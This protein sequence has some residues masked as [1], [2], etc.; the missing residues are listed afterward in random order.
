MPQAALADG[1]R[2]GAAISGDRRGDCRAGGGHLGGVSIRSPIR[3]AD[4]G[5]RACTADYPHRADLAQ[6][7]VGGDRPG[8]RDAGWLAA[9][10]VLA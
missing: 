10:L 3:L 7:R 5:G 9:Q 6:C 4:R 2:C 1:D 8:E